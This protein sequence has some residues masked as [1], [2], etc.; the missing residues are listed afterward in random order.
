MMFK[1]RGFMVLFLCILSAFFSWIALNAIVIINNYEIGD[2]NGFLYENAFS[3]L[4]GAAAAL[5]LSFLFSGWASK[6]K[7]IGTVCFL[8]LL[9]SITTHYTMFST[10]LI[11]GWFEIDKTD[12][13]LESLSVSELLDVSSSRNPNV[14]YSAWQ[15][16]LRRGSEDNKLLVNYLSDQ[17]NNFSKEYANAMRNVQVAE[18]LAKSKNKEVVPYLE[19]M[20]SSEKF[21]EVKNPD[22]SVEKLYPIRKYAKGYLAEYF[23]QHADDVVVTE[24]LKNTEAGGDATTQ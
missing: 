12:R 23:G 2:F 20:L 4:L 21:V 6:I 24:T 19:D 3:P 1:G 22:G 17:K 14:A 13:S 15:E 7:F 5:I 18:V 16:F 10:G 8:S 11:G 9:L